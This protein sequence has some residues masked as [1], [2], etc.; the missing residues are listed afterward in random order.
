M[1]AFELNCLAKDIRGA[2]EQFNDGNC[3]TL[4]ANVV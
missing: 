3:N 2:I 1:G 4:M